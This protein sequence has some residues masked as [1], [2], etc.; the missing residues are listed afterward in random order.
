MDI[1]KQNKVLKYG[2]GDGL[3]K[4]WTG[5]VAN[6]EALRIVNKK[7][8]ILATVFKTNPFW[9]RHI[10]RR[11]RLEGREKEKANLQTSPRTSQK[12]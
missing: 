1:K 5:I 3:K 7:P 10:L 6:G 4:N 9:V 11:R 2:I 12:T 8:S